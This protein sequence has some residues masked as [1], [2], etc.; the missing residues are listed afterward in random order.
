MADARHPDRERSHSQSGEAYDYWRNHDWRGRA[1]FFRGGYNYAVSTQNFN[2]VAAI[3]SLLGGKPDRRPLRHGRRPPRART[4]PL[5]Y[6]SFQ[7]GSSQEVLDHYYLS[8]TLSAQKM[9][10]DYGPTAFDRLAG[11]IMLERTMEMLASVYHPLLGRFVGPSGRARLPG[12]LV[13]QDGI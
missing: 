11:R 12:V 1:S 2:H 4:L 6:W 13:E 3:G 9:F 10:A 5:P 7:D 8:I